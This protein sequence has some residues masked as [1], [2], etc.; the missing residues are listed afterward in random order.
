MAEPTTTTGTATD[1]APAATAGK[2]HPLAPAAGIANWVDQRLGAAKLGKSFVRKIFP[3][4]WSFLLG[5]IAL[6]SFI[7]LLL[8]GVFLT[9]WFKPTM[10]EVIYDGSYQF[11]RGLH[12]SEAYASTLD[13][14]F[15]IR[16]GL[17][18]RQ[19]HHWAAMLFIG[20]MTAHMLRIFFTGAFRKPRE[21]N[22]LIGLALL[23]LGIV[24]GFAG[25]SLPD[26][27]LSGTG[28]RI[29]DGLMRSVPIV[30]TWVEVLI[31][32]GE[33][34]G[35]IIITRFYMAHILLV[36]GIILGLIAAHLA[37][38]VYHKHTQFPGPGRTE[39]NVVGYPVFPVYAAKAGGFFFIVF[40]VTA[41]MGAF[42]QINPLWTYGP[43]NPAEVTAGSQPDWYMGFAEGALRIM[44]G[45]ETHFAG[46]GFLPPATWSWNVLIPGVGGLGI[47]FVVLG[48]YPFVEQW[49]TGD[50]RDHNVLQYPWQAPNRTAFGVAGMTAYGILWMAGG[51]D[52]L[53]IMFNLSL[54]F[55]TELFRVLI[56][57][58]P[59]VAFIVTKR[60]CLG[61]QRRN[62][63]RVLHGSESGLMERSPSGE[64]HEAHV[65]ISEDEAYLLTGSDEEHPVAATNGDAREL[66]GKKGVVS[67]RR[68]L[69]SR[70]YYADNVPKPTAEE[71]EEAH[72]HGDHGDH[73]DHGVEGGDHNELESS[74]RH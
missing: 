12:M 52:I 57:V 1:A 74:D 42:L 69:V 65:P 44:P 63:E 45:W 26:D 32:G 3:D 25:Y 8:T 61:I 47:L 48:V 71:I 40:G 51:N 36:P 29:A 15:D 46:W 19:M 14:S 43:Y 17:L 4:H 7:I 22:W 23:M 55:L 39:R 24:E 56:F 2:P 54:N 73:D 34:P 62:V 70:W 64:Y 21:V 41:L 37:L 35:D 6:Y 5:E 16:G 20:A 27:L 28:L 31:F 50:K 9:L 59:V 33:Y 66:K 13:I 67:K 30:G 18:M 11:Y 58:G 60:I 68:A 10:G 49:V 38:V 72:H 53:A